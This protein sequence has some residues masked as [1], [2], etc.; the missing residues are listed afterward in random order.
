MLNKSYLKLLAYVPTLPRLLV[1]HKTLQRFLWN[2]VNI[3]EIQEHCS[4]AWHVCCTSDA[5]VAL[6][7]SRGTRRVARVSFMAKLYRFVSIFSYLYWCIVSYTKYCDAPI[8]QVY[9]FTPSKQW[10]MCEMLGISLLKGYQVEALEALCLDK[11]NTLVCVPTGS[12]NSACFE[13]GLIG[14]VID[15]R[16]CQW[17]S[18]LVQHLWLARFL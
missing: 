17:A 10:K 3:T 4:A 15:P 5:S 9:R 14:T 11:R 12:R 13:V 16:H 7:T 18:S 8:Y 2:I 1:L 6:T